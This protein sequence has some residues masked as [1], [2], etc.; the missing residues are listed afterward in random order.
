MPTILSI[1]FGLGQTNKT[2][3]DNLL[4]DAS[5]VTH[6]QITSPT[7]IPFCV[8]FESQFV[9]A[10][11]VNCVQDDVSSNWESFL[12]NR[13]QGE[14]AK[15]SVDMYSAIHPKPSFRKI[16]S[17]KVKPEAAIF[18]LIRQYKRGPVWNKRRHFR[19]DSP[20]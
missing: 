1:S 10:S 18:L 12:D 16:T 20:V 9:F 15:P 17:R 19:F 8:L 7:E 11:N 4:T 2:V 3:M 13:V 6:Q 14:E 5:A